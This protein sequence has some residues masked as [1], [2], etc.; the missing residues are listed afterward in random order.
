MFADSIGWGTEAIAL[1]VML[2]ALLERR[3]LASLVYGGTERPLES[4]RRVLIGAVLLRRRT[5]GGTRST[6]R[7]SSPGT[8]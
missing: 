5:G 3:R 1:D 6:P 8:A 4:R 2:E 7:R